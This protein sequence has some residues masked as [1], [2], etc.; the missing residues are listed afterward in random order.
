LAKKAAKHKQS[1]KGE[2]DEPSQG[3]QLLK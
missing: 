1:T 3:I 2:G